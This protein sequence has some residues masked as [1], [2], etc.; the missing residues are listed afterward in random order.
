MDYGK[1]AAS[2]TPKVLAAVA[3]LNNPEIT[4]A[5]RQLNQEILLREVGKSIYDK[6]YDMNAFDMEIAHTKG[7]GIDERFYGLAK[8]SSNS[9]SNGNAGLQEYVQNY[10]FATSSK[11]QKDAMTTARQ[12][13]KRPRVKRTESGDACE[14]CQSK[15]GTYDN[16]GSDVF[17]R[18]GG[19]EGKIVTEGFKSRNGELSNYKKPSTSGVGAAAPIA[20][21]GGQVVFRGT[22]KNVSSA[23]LELG[24]G[25]YVARSGQTASTFGNVSQLS[26]PLKSKDILQ[27][28]SDNQYEKLVLDAQRWAVRNNKSLDANDFI[29]LYVRNLGYKAAEIAPAVDPL[30]GIAVYDPAVIKKLQ[31]QMK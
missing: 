21:D 5:V 24:T 11:A 7:S 3:L 6:I 29:P 10:L 30:G 22:G 8:V 31:K 2:L 16:P 20:P 4:P 25:F 1:L 28:A 9:V 23:G 19:C 27:I 17:E 15:V 13:G 12:S 14:W 18:H 26:L